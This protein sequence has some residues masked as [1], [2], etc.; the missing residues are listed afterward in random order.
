MA[1]TKI[2]NAGF[3]L[4]T[5][6]L[7]GVAASFSSTVS[8]GGTLT[9]E[10]VTN[11]DSVGLITARNGI[12]VTDKGVQVGTGATVD[13]AAANTLTFLT[14]GSERVRVTSDGKVGINTDM[15]GAPASLYPF[16][17]YRSTGTGYVYTETAQSGASAGFRAKAG[18]ADFTIFTTQGTGQ[19]AVYDNTNSAERLRI[20]SAGDMGLGA[21]PAFSNGSGFEV[22]RSGTAC[23]RIE[24]N[25]GN[26]AL[27]AY[28]D[29]NGATLDAR[30]SSANLMF[31]IGGSE[32]L[33]IDSS[34]SLLVNTSTSRSVMDQAGN[35]PTPKLQIEG[36]D[37]NGIISVISAGDADANRCGTIN[38]GRHRN[39][40]VG[41]TPTI[42]QNG[43]ALGAVVFSGGDGG[44]MLTC[45]AKIHAVVDGAPGANDMP[46]ALIFS[47]TP[48]G[49]GHG[50][51]TEKM[52]INSA[53][54]LGVGTNS[55]LNGLLTLHQDDDQ[56][57]LKQTDGDSGFLL[58]SNNTNGNLNLKRR[59]V[60]SNT[61][62]ATFR[63][64][65]GL[66]FNGDTAAANAL[67]DYEEGTFTPTAQGS[68][69][70][71]TATYSSQLGKYTKI[72][73]RVFFEIY[74]HWSSG[75]GSGSAL[76]VY[77][78]PFTAQSSSQTYPATT[79]G[80]FH[81]IAFAANSSPGALVASGSTYVY[82]YA[83]PNGGGTNAAIAYDSG[84]SMILTG[85]YKVN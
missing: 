18:T 83:I 19:L 12:E 56:L 36:E 14:G 38:L 51:N 20:T 45:G 2:T 21:T 37:S 29:S 1:F 15:G 22:A 46:G 82:F 79:I 81:N 47:T 43:D 35:G 42:V 23:I 25:S 26:H 16:S 54:K 77:G 59:S 74:V 66:T 8:V 28:A 44:D 7:V 55:N 71:G 64:A 78:L 33:R 80:Y 60:G 5:G 70:A 58:G 75:T 67:D 69:V 85:H 30:G 73:D 11:V 3:G 65:G 34:G 76:Y 17:V 32:R 31:D 10:D 84:G 61:T 57:F 13:S 41:G 9:Y 48:D 50:F 62:I 72:G 39:G 53:G 40:T 68:T 49:Q 4:T 27:E 52:R 63:A 6:T 24:G